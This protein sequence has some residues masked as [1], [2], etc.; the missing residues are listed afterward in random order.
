MKYPKSL[1]IGLSEQMLSE[2]ESLIETTPYTKPTLVRY[3][4]AQ[5]IAERKAELAAA[6]GGSDI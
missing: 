6:G 5:W 1:A 3:L 4:I 2:F